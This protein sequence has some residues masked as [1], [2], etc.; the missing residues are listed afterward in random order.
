MASMSPVIVEI[1]CVIKL[2]PSF[3]KH[4]IRHV[5]IKRRWK[6]AER[7]VQTCS[8]A[9]WIVEEL[10]KLEEDTIINERGASS[11]HGI[12]DRTSD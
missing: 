5:R 6:R 8:V 9:P 11:D 12:G 2:W 3:W 7:L 4:P 10:A 1:E